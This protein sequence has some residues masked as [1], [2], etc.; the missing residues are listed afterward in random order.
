MPAVPRPGSTRSRTRTHALDALTRA[1]SQSSIP[2]RGGNSWSKAGMADFRS[3]PSSS[4]SGRWGVRGSR[5]TPTCDDVYSFST[6]AASSCVRSALGSGCCHSS[7]GSAMRGQRGGEPAHEGPPARAPFAPGH[8]RRPPSP[9]APRQ[10]P[11]VRRIARPASS[12]PHWRQ[13]NRLARDVVRQQRHLG[14]DRALR[15]WAIVKEAAAR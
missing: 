1:M 6:A 5:S 11:P 3:V 2:S 7:P 13:H 10:P 15:R 4:C 14:V 9:P 12:T 8:A